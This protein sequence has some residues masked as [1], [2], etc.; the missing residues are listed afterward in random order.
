[1]HRLDAIV[2]EDVDVMKMD[3]EGFGRAAGGGEGGGAVLPVVLG[4]SGS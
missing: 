4:H 3:V 2:H 1:M